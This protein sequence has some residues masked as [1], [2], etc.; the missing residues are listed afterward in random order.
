MEASALIYVQWGLLA[1]LTLGLL[2]IWA[3]FGEL[4]FVRRMGGLTRFVVGLALLV[5][6]GA[7][8]LGPGLA[9]LGKV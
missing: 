4:S 6:M 2:C 9:G 8:V 3:D 7:T 1:A 5:A